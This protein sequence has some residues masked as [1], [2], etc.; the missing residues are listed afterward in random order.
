M[1]KYIAIT[2]LALAGATSLLAQGPANATLIFNDNGAAGGTASSGTYA[3]GSTIV[4]DITLHYTAGPPADANG[5]SYWFESRLG[6]TGTGATAPGIFSVASLAFTNGVLTSPW[7]DPQTNSPTFPDAVVGTTGNTQDLGA[8]GTDVT[9]NATDI[10][11][12]RISFTISGTATPGTYTLQD[13][14]SAE[15]FAH[16]A[17][18][19]DAA[20]FNSWDLPTTLYTVT[21]VPEPTTWSLIA[22]GGLGAFGLNLLRARRKS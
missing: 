6:S 18:I 11:I 17:V 22:L 8:S 4:F 2:L 5:I 3:P 13:L 7:T 14:T 9:P 16:G 21:I 10:F 1:K 19:S 12:A 20:T 15:N